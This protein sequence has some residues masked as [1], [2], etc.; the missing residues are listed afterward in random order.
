[1]IKTAK[2]EKVFKNGA[3]EAAIFVNEINKDG[4]KIEI[5]K[6][7]VQRRYKDK[8]GNWQGTNSLDIN[9]IPK[10]VMA[11]TKAYNYLTEKGENSVDFVP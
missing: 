1:M 5:K 2:P 4:A 11:L 6:V 3:C 7:V 9:D 8:D 10:A